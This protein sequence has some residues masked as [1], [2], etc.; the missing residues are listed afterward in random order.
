MK[1]LAAFLAGLNPRASEEVQLVP[2]YVSQR[3]WIT[4]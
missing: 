4:I 3:A 2:R 1:Q